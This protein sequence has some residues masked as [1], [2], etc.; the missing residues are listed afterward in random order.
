[1]LSP[2][3]KNLKI[4]AGPC[5]VNKDSLNELFDIAQIKINSKPAVW[6]LRVVGLKS[7][8]RFTM[9]QRE[10][11]VDLKTFLD[12]QQTVLKS[13]SI[14][15]LKVPKSV[16]IAFKVYSETKLLVATEIM[17]PLIQIPFYE[18]YF[19]KEKVLFWNPAVNQLGWP[20]L[21]AGKFVE[22]NKWFLGIKNPK[23]LGGSLKNSLNGEKETSF[24]KTWRG[25][26]SYARVSKKR[27][28]LIHRGI[29]IAQKRNFR[30]YPVHSLAERV[31]ERTG[32]NL[33]FDP[34][35]TLGEKMREKI[36]PYT[37]KAM[38]LLTKKG[39]FLYD[40][41]LIEVGRSFTDT[42]QHLSIEEFKELCYRL[43]KFRILEGG[44]N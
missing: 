42:N 9:S 11:G 35:H 30:N 12:N 14:A 24:E 27:L 28:I 7:R 6:G 37:L 2:R 23:W 40:G 29:D 34:S 33:F 41:I 25:L 4:I 31:K 8:T 21:S 19:P 39:D 38:S 43:S 26:T 44:G 16:K 3:N 15:A 10:M 1:M 17:D 18:K 13:K 22:R 20:L 36:I 5:S 32:L